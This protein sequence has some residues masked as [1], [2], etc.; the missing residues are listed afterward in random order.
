MKIF[1]PFK[2]QKEFGFRLGNE[3]EMLIKSENEKSV[4]LDLILKKWDIID[5]AGSIIL[6]G[7]VIEKKKLSEMEK[8]TDDE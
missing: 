3:R 1:N 7:E 6:L 5:K 8:E 4:L 2:K